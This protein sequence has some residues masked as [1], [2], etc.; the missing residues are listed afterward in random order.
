MVV[1]PYDR[2]P[3]AT[4]HRLIEE[5]VTRDGTDYGIQEVPLEK[6]VENVM[7]Q[8]RQG[9]TFVVFDEQTESANLITREQLQEAGLD[10]DA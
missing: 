2:L 8:L 10:P 3:E 6:R 4:L 5:F 1:V 7:R 9:A